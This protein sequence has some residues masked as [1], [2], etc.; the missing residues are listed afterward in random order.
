MSNEITVL[1][2]GRKTWASA[3]LPRQTA[4]VVQHATAP[5]R[6][7]KCHS[8]SALPKNTV[9]RASA[10]GKLQ[11]PLQGQGRESFNHEGD[12]SKRLATSS[13]LHSA[14]DAR[15]KESDAVIS[16]A[17][18]ESTTSRRQSNIK[19][20]KSS[21]EHRAEASQS[22]QSDATSITV[23]KKD[24]C[25]VRVM[26]SVHETPSVVN[27]Q[28]ERTLPKNMP[29]RS[30]LREVSHVRENSS[31]HNVNHSDGLLPA[32]SDVRRSLLRYYE[33]PQGVSPSELVL[34]EPPIDP[35]KVKKLL[36]LRKEKK[37][38]A[39]TQWEIC[40]MDQYAVARGLRDAK[41][42]VSYSVSSQGCS[43]DQNAAENFS[44]QSHCSGHVRFSSSTLS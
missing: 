31:A 1:K 4:H 39:F 20:A 23:D 43:G 14:R 6:R 5:S 41:H 26:P 16:P 44:S 25:R 30:I 32:R 34:D 38:L 42:A 27:K 40:C 37:K 18:V 12:A 29:S 22:L 7:H 19:P 21:A 33:N 3:D 24:R 15:R 10:A 28:H 8:C 36:K 11:D 9:S 13:Q 2:R 17:S 35:R